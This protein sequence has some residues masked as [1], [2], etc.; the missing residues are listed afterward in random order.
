VG[1]ILL[2]PHEFAIITMSATIFDQNIYVGVSSKEEMAVVFYNYTCC[3]FVGSFHAINMDTMK[4]SWSAYGFPV[5]KYPTG[6]G[7]LSGVAYW[8]SS[9]TIDEKRNLV[10]VATGIILSNQIYFKFY[11][12]I[13]KFDF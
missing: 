11:F 6:E 8:G 12:F 5:E 2:D 4:I 7:G 13:C 1:K 9:P 10:Y 3:S